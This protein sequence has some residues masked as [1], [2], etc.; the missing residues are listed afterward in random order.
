MAIALVEYSSEMM[1][2]GGETN[3]VYRRGVEDGVM[4]SLAEVTSREIVAV[5]PGANV[6]GCDG[7][8]AWD[9]PEGNEWPLL[10][11]N[12]EGSQPELSE[13]VTVRM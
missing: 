4:A 3:T 12:S 10:T 1:N 8:N 11:K 5:D 6:K 7:L 9:Q 2:G 13:L